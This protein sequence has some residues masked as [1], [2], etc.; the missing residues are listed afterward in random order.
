MAKERPI[1]H[2]LGVGA[3]SIIEYSTGV[4][5]YRQ[6]G[7]LLPAFRLSIADVTGFATRKPP[8]KTRRTVQ[9]PSQ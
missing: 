6:T 9:A 2:G 4:V 5:E 1:S 3:G 7:K 8:D